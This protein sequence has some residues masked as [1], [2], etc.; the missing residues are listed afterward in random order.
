[1]ILFLTSSGSPDVSL[2]SEILQ[3]TTKHSSLGIGLPR[4]IFGEISRKNVKIAENGEGNVKYECLL[5]VCCSCSDDL[6]FGKCL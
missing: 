4:A 6:K 5:E 1:M 2:S 3:N